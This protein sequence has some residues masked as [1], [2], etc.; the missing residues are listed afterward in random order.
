MASM[1]SPYT[2]LGTVALLACFTVPMTLAAPASDEHQLLTLILRQ[3]DAIDRLSSASTNAVIDT[4]ARYTFDYARL[5]ADLDLIRQGI[6]GYLTPS[7]AQPRHPPELTGHY[8]R[9]GQRQP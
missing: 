6:S 8:T 4:Q 3:L 9:S 5:S 1:P 7:R 2:T